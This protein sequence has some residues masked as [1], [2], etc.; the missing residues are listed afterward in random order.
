MSKNRIIGIVL[1]LVSIGF[2]YMTSQLPESKYSTA[3][4]PD[5]FPYLSAGGLLLCAIAI[6]F[7]RPTEKDK[8]PFL[9]KAGW[10]RALKMSV[11]ICLFPLLFHFLGFIIASLALL[12]P[13]ILIFD[14]ENKEAAWKAAIITI[15]LTLVIMLIFE[16][17][18]NTSLPSGVFFDLLRE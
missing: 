7:R 11:L 10:M 9:D 13:M 8:V 6:F 12:F 3:I 5:A 16:K 15:V 14:L 17:L 18:L 4:G 1:G 2:L